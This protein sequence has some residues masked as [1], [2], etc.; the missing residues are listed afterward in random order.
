MYWLMSIYFQKIRLNDADLINAPHKFQWE[1]CQ[2]RAMLHGIAKL[3]M[4]MK[5]FSRCLSLRDVP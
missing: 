3:E 2:T 5:Q 4:N 1:D